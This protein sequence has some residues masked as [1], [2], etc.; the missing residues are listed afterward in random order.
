MPKASGHEIPRRALGRTGVEVSIL[1]L[2]GY[3]LG[4][5]KTRRAGVRLTQQAIDAGITF[6]D[7]AWE[8][9][10]GVTEEIMGQALTGG[11]RTS[12]FLMS[13][14]CSH[15][16]GKNVA[17]RQLH[18][19]LRRLKVDY[20]DLW[21]IHEVAY[22]NDA[23]LHFAREGAIE[24]LEQAKAQGKV[25]FVGFTGHKH[26]DYHLDMLRYGFAFDT[27]QLPLNC[28]DARF[29]SFEQRVL[30]ELNRQGIAALGM[31]AICANGRPVR[32]KAVTAQ[33]ALRY[34]MSLPVATTITGIDSLHVLEQDLAIA[35][36]FRPMNPSKME[37]LRRRCAPFGADGRF[38]LYKTTALHEGPIGR[39]QHGFPPP[40]VVEA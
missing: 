18:Q 15:G 19:S 9:H 8:Y 30:P 28:F 1:G 39:E 11:R 36:G 4:L 21:Q 37:A 33:E 22:E 6:L 17:M 14:L 7:N 13:K 40:E 16:R 3:H 23:A 5:L 20:L 25:R 26:P 31:K 34:A 38:E 2:G 32:Q 35:R 27:C 12:V 29:R 24:A 10:D